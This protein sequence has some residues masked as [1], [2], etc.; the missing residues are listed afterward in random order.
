[1]NLVVTGA[2]VAGVGCP[3]ELRFGGQRAIVPA[4]RSADDQGLIDADDI[5]AV[6][7]PGQSWWTLAACLAHLSRMAVNTGLIIGGRRAW[8][9]GDYASWGAGR[10]HEHGSLGVVH[11]GIGDAAQEP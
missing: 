10:N 1:V 7:A 3:I 8:L 6:F 2:V 9:A 5:A 4:A 11:Q